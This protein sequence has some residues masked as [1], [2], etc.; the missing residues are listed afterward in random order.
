[1]SGSYAIT[2][3]QFRTDYPAFADRVKYA[4][5]DVQMYLDLAY[6][7]LS[8]DRWGEYYVMGQ[9]LFAA[10]HLVLDA[11][12]NAAAAKGALPGSAGFLASSKSVGGVSVSYDLTGTADARGQSWNTT[13]YGRRYWR[14]AAMAGSSP[15]QV[16]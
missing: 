12:D 16:V 1:M 15:L 7:S 5:R 6:A 3:D 14:L 4:D 11:A 2:P 9:E 10:H 13:M 8:S